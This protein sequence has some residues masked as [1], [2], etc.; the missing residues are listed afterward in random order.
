MFAKPPESPEHV[1]A[2]QEYA[3]N[4]NPLARPK[5]SLDKVFLYSV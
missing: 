4:V 1:D 5:H 2:V 3:K